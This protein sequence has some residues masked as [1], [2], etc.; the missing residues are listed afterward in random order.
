LAISIKI[1]SISK[2]PKEIGSEDI[3]LDIQF[4]PAIWRGIHPMDKY[5]FGFDL[6]MII[7]YLNLTSTKPVLC[8]GQIK[9]FFMNANFIPNDI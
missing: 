3:I 7:I 9:I 5:W 2:S 8:T 6:L 1:D 4:Q